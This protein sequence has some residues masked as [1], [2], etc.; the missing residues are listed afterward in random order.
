MSNSRISAGAARTSASAGSAKVVCAGNKHHRDRTAGPSSF[1]QLCRTGRG[2]LPGRWHL[3]TCGWRWRCRQR[4][5]RSVQPHSC[6]SKRSSGRRK[7]VPCTP[8]RKARHTAARR[9][10]PIQTRDSIRSG[11]D[12]ASLCPAPP[13]PLGFEWAAEALPHRLKS[14]PHRARKLLKSGTGFSL[15]KAS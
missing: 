3:G 11:T 7:S 12:S 6:A 9:P 10:R 1:W 15:W 2:G 4:Q 14:V 13:A 5:M 8:S